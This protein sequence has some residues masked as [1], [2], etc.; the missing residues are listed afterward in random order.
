MRSYGR[1]VFRTPDGRRVEDVPAHV[2]LENGISKAAARALGG[3]D[4]FW[5]TAEKQI[6]SFFAR[7]NPAGGTPAI[8]GLE[9]PTASL[10][11]LLRSG[12]VAIDR[13]GAYIV[14]NWKAFNEAVTR[15]FLVE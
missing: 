8:A 6:A 11:S 9:I 5:A 13:T 10:Q 3:G 14:K 7:A 1:L 12:G 2:V 15:R 4:V